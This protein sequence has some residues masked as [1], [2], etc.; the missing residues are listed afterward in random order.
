MRK[1]KLSWH[2]PVNDYT[3]DYK[4]LRKSGNSIA[5]NT[6]SCHFNQKGSHPFV[7]ALQWLPVVCYFSG[8]KT[9]ST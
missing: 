2:W 9:P 6:F 8:F 7:L 1:E 3:A 5:G 4:R